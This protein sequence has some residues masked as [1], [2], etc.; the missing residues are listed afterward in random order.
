MLK[1]GMVGHACNLSH[2]EAEAGG[3]LVQG[4]LGQT[5]RPHLKNTKKPNK[6]TDVS[7]TR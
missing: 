2:G 5:T 3:L 6:E 1:S 4:N 7:S